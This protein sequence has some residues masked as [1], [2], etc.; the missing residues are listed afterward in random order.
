MIKADE[1]VKKYPKIFVNRWGYPSVGNGWLPIVDK[2][3]EKIQNYVDDTANIEQV[4]VSQIKEKFASLCYY[5]E[6]GD[7]YVY[8]VIREGEKVSRYTCECC[9]TK[10]NVGRTYNGW[11][12]TICDNC[13]K[14][15]DYYKGRDWKLNTEQYGDIK[16]TLKHN[17]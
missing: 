10:E 12:L 14:T 8:D 2:I 1:I 11:S 3:C 4:V 15:V 16:P 17:F 9:G 5:I 13:H 6:S 7:N